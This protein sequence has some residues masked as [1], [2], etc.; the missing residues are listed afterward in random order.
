MRL[1]LHVYMR[2]ELD[3]AVRWTVPL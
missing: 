3:T 2:V 1:G